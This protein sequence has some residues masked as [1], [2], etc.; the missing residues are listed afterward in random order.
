MC[1][2]GLRAVRSET[3]PAMAAWVAGGLVP[4]GVPLQW[5]AA[6]PGRQRTDLVN[7]T[8]NGGP[9][10]SVQ[11]GRRRVQWLQRQVEQGDQHPVDEDQLVIGPG[12]GRPPRYGASSR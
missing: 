7:G 12:T 6:A 2:V 9:G 1:R 8:G 5:H 3:R 4:S 11:L 10:R